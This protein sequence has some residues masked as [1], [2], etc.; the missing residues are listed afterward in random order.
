M[1]QDQA[2]EFRAALVAAVAGFELDQLSEEHSALLEKHYG[3]LRKW[4]L[5]INLTRIIDA[6]EAAKFHYAESLF[7]AQFILSSKT[8]L[9]IG[10]GAGFP[11]IPLAVVR[12]DVQVTALEVNQKKALFLKEVKDELCLANLKVET[13][14][15]EEFNWSGYDFL[16]SRAL[17]H[18]EAILRSVIERLD[19]KQRLMLYC[20]PELIAKLEGQADNKIEIHPIPCSESRMLAIFSRE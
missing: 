5:K 9:D 6:R 10:S 7:G 1:S 19:V 18:A 16:T 3:M 15:L 12:P 8:L 4:N 2:Y 14:R 17:D 20:A 13:A 11:A